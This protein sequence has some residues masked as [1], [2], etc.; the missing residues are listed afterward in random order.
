MKMR[1]LG[2]DGP[3]VSAIA[4]GCMSFAGFYGK[5]TREESFATLDAAREAGI[6]FLDTAELYGKGLSEQ[7]IGDW[8]ADRGHR[9]QIA[10]KGGIVLGGARGENNNSEPHLRRALEGSLTRLGVDRVAL[11][12]VHRRDWSIPIEEVTETLEGFREEGLIGGFGY[13][14][15]APN[16]LR[17]AASVAPVMAVQNEYSLWTRQPDLGLIRA[18]K[19]LGTTFVPFSP[20]GRGIFSDTPMPNGRAEAL[21]FLHANPR[22]VEPNLSANQAV[23]QRFRQFCRARGWSVPAAALAWVLDQGDH[24][25]PIPA[26]RTAD[27]LRDWADA[28]EIAFTNDDRAEIDRIMPPGWAHGDRY[29]DAQIVGIERYC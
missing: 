14:E 12:Y 17:R 25:V 27:H 7:I 19:E 18:C 5:T 9:F 1:R 23:I 11:Y 3:E 21:P 13:S 26:T 22:F 4:L 20:L 28:S 24:L 16:S 15:I 6:T 29:S 2:R 8:M 10:T